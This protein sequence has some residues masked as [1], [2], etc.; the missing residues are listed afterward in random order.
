[1]AKAAGVQRRHG[2]PQR[3]R[4]PRQRRDRIGGAPRLDRGARRCHSARPSTAIIAIRRI[5]QSGARQSGGAAPVSPREAERPEQEV[6]RERQQ[7]RAAAAAREEQQPL[8]D[9]AAEPAHAPL[10][11][12]LPRQGHLQ[13]KIHRVD[14][15]FA[16]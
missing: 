6:E 8:A 7:Q 11:A 2:P 1:M 13:G 10:H 5:K 12:A 3:L 14:P 15:K 16:S 4:V 9:P